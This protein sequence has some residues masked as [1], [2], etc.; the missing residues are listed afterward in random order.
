M[1]NIE[2]VLVELSKDVD[3]VKFSESQACRATLVT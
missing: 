1:F 2:L 3:P